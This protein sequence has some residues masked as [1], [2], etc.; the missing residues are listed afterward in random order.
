MDELELIGLFRRSDATPNPV[1]R[2]AARDRLIAHIAEAEAVVAHPATSPFSFLLEADLPKASFPTARDRLGYTRGTQ[3]RSGSASLIA[4]MDRVSMDWCEALDAERAVCESTRLL[5]GVAQGRSDPVR[6][7]ALI[8]AAIEPQY[9]G[10][11]GKPILVYEALRAAQS[12]FSGAE[13]R[14][15]AKAHGDLKAPERIFL[16]PESAYLL[17]RTLH[18][19]GHSRLALSQAYANL[20]FLIDVATPNGAFHNP[21]DG[22]DAIC[23]LLK[24]Q[25]RSPLVE[26]TVAALSIF[27]A[28]IRR[29]DQ[30]IK[31]ES[32][33]R[34]VDE[35]RVLVEAH[36]LDDNGQ[37]DGALLIHPKTAVLAAQ[38]FYLFARHGRPGDEALVE[39]LYRLDSRARPTHARGQATRWL[40]EAE[41]ARHLKDHEREQRWTRQA[42]VDLEPLGV[43]I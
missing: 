35:C 29:N 38:G 13:A 31:A 25:V 34:L 23:K 16:H 17:A 24:S 30:A 36:V 7:V 43:D 15:V 39:A 32:L 26:Q 6:Y 12:T 4:Q 40:L 41:W 8:Q 9:D 37:L 1:A 21:R 2:A 33:Q 5:E 42:F 14:A 27:M 18:V 19:M 10:P 11:S 28:T 22:H 20:S 3:R